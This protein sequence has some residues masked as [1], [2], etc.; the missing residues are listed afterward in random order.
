[1]IEALNQPLL[2]NPA[3]GFILDNVRQEGEENRNCT[4]C[5]NRDGARV[6]GAA[7]RIF[8][9]GEHHYHEGCIRDSLAR[10]SRCP[11]PGCEHEI[12]YIQDGEQ[13]DAVQPIRQA[14]RIQIEGNELPRPAEAI[15]QQDCGPVR[16][17]REARH[18]LAAD[19][20]EGNYC[21]RA[22]KWLMMP[23]VVAAIGATILVATPIY[24]LYK[25]VNR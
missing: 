9:H 11:Y 7:K 3:D 16:W 13:I 8:S 14:V 4:L 25:A 17:V 6:E 2:R 10:D 18:L 12:T 15:E 21:A 23:C 24:Y 20:R 22:S 5:Q 19:L 1:M